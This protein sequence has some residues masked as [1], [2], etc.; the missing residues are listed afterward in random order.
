MTD[1]NITQFFLNNPEWREYADLVVLP[2]L[3]S[4]AQ[5]EFPE[6]EESELERTPDVILPFGVTRL[7]LYMKMRRS[8]LSHRFAEMAALQRAPRCMTDDVFFAGMPRLAE[9]MTPKVLRNVVAAAR[10]H[11]YNPSPDATYH[12]GLARFQGDPE[13]FVTRSQGRGYIKRLCERRGWAC[14]GAVTVAARPPEHDYADQSHATPMAEKLI[15]SH[16]RDM[17]TKDPSL[18]RLNRQALREKV[19]QTHG[20]ST[21]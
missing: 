10:R 13:A 4:E 6:L 8:G 20:P 5:E 11:G 3:L 9:Q 2:P 7:A 21:T 15:Q 14:D 18:A 12:S 16:A 19:L 17:V 1:F